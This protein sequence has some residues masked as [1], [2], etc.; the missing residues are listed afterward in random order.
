M[1]PLT[2]QNIYIDTFFS[3]LFFSFFLFSLLEQYFMCVEQSTDTTV[4]YREMKILM[5]LLN[6]SMIQ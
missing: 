1:F 3:F 2:E 6:K 4:I 5:I